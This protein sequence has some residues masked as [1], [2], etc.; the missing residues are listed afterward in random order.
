MPWIWYKY[1]NTLQTILQKKYFENNIAIDIS[2]KYNYNWNLLKTILLKKYIE[3]NITAERL[4]K[5][6]YYRN[7]PEII[8]MHWKLLYY[9]NE[10][11]MIM[12]QKWNKDDIRVELSRKYLFILKCT[13]INLAIEMHLKWYD[14][15][16]EI[17]IILLLKCS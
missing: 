9:R 4:R 1:R 10:M 3:S 7:P 16:N 15:R 11:K 12:Q 14:Y 13:V 17:K 8:Q 5:G 2:R 6:Y